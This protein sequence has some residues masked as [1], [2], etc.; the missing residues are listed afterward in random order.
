MSARYF[1]LWLLCFL[2]TNPLPA[3]GAP[4]TDDDLPDY[5]PGLIAEFSTNGKTHRRVDEDLA[6]DWDNNSHDARLAVGR[7]RVCWTG[8]LFVHRADAYRLSVQCTGQ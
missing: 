8:R 3:Q 4:P 7:F 1:L 6:F 2:G 5:L